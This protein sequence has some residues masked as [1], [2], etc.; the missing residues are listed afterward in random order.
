[1]AQNIITLFEE[2]ARRFPNRRALA[3]AQE[4]WTFRTLRTQARRVASWLLNQGYR[5]R[6]LGILARRDVWTG[7]LFL[8][9]AYSG[10]FYVPLDEDMPREKLRKIL[11][12]G[13]IS[14][15]LGRGPA[16]ELPGYL[17][18][19]DSLLAE[20]EEDQTAL[21]SLQAELEPQSLLYVVYTSGSTGVPKGVSKTHGAMLSFL[22]AYTRTF[23]FSERDVLGNQTPFFFDASAKDF[24]LMAATGAALEILPT[25]LFSFPVRLMEYLNQRQVNFISWVPSALSIVTQLNTF[26]EVLPTTLNRVFFVGEVFPQKQLDRWRLAL[27]QAEFVNLYGS[28]EIAGVACYYRVPGGS[29]DTQALPIGGPLPNCTVHLV[30]QDRIVVEPGVVGELYLASPALAAGYYQDPERTAISFPTL[31]LGDG[32]FRRYFRTGDLARYNE[33]GELV[34]AARRDYQIKHMGRRIELGEIET[35]ADSLEAVQRCCCLYDSKKQKIVLFCQLASDHISC[36]GR[37]IRRLL[38][39]NLSDYMVPAKVIL[40]ERLPLNANGKIDRQALA[41]QLDARPSGAGGQEVL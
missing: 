13:E 31:D 27:P 5:S 17:D 20:M 39:E 15:V 19:T 33:A 9:A 26:A 12:G 35:A 14:L 4:A 7:A 10:N 16:Q 8:A 1:M 32:V 41:R 22:D 23:P 2:T 40:L 30:D 36:T 21:A 25:E 24:Y 28:S 29:L 11:T 18:I 3:D 6:P 38:R 37:E 34:F